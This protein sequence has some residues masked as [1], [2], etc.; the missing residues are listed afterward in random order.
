MQ[1]E[2]RGTH[3]TC[4]PPF[5]VVWDPISKQW[6]ECQ[7][8]LNWRRNI[9]RA[10]EKLAGRPIPPSTTGPSN[11]STRQPSG[12]PQRPH[13]EGK[14][15]HL[16]VI[17]GGPE[18]YPLVLGTLAPVA[19]PSLSVSIN[20]LI[21]TGCLFSNFCKE[22]IARQL[23]DL[24]PTA[25]REHRV[26]TLADGSTVST[27]GS[28][29]CNLRL[30]CNTV[31]VSL[32]SVT[33]HVLPELAFDVILGYPTIKRYNLLSAF[34]SLFC[35]ADLQVHNCKSCRQCLPAV[36]QQ[37]C[38]LASGAT[39]AEVLLEAH[40]SG[41]LNVPRDSRR[42]SEGGLAVAVIQESPRQSRRQEEGGP[43][44]AATQERLLSAIPS[45]TRGPHLQAEGGLDGAAIAGATL[46]PRRL[47]EGGVD[48]ACSQARNKQ[49]Q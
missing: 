33:M 37:E 36:F 41:A 49:V 27:V 6:E 20:C 13:A 40:R 35:E 18:L 2:A 48:V 25:D 15:L 12:S 38:T 45:A 23:T 46:K 11:R 16:G 26:V 1:R 17:R 7:A 47:A 28:V 21:D 9:E 39:Q 4:L 34:Y 10:R 32:K 30:T 24:T 22:A 3:L 44:A 43:S 31:A 14:P 29:V 19:T 5:G 42:S 8:L